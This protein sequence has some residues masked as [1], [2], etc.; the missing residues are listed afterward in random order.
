MTRR[1]LG[2]AL[3]LGGSALALGL[4]IG[5][6][7]IVPLYD[8]VVIAEPYRY[9]H[10]TGDQAGDPTS[11]I[12]TVAITGPLSPALA[13]FTGE[14]PPQA[15]LIAQEGAFALP[16]GATAI[17]AEIVPVDPPTPLPDTGP[18]SGNAYRFSVTDQAGNM[19]RFQACATCVSIALRSPDGS[20]RGQLMQ[21]RN[22]AWE[23]LETRHGG[24]GLYQAN[25]AALGIVAVVA[26]P[27]GVDVVL[28]L[29]IGGIALIFIAFV[30]LLYLRARPAALP[31]ARLPSGGPARPPTRIPAKKRRGS[32]RPP[33]GRSDQ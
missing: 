14:S 20:L 28:L 25:L 10:P 23:P 16:D 13:P 3:V 29:A 31:A 32:K 18:I 8:G 5:A 33:P 15:Q 11:A 2:A 7:V 19:L 9:L 24:A 17:L 6:P 30:A 21:Y 1:R 22:G 26:T 12:R 4:Q 27:A